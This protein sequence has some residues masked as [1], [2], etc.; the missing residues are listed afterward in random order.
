MDGKGPIETKQRRRVDIKDPVITACVSEPL[1][2]GLKTTNFLVPIGRCQRE[3][4]IGG[5]Q[6]RKT[7]VAIDTIINQKRFGEETD[8]KTKLYCIWAAAG[9]KQSTIT[10]LISRLQSIDLMK[11]CIVLVASA[12]YASPLQYLAPTPQHQWESI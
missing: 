9:Q 11:Y 5:R 1:Q 8:E 2:T 12:A 7:V 4:F 10:R 3:L 6:T